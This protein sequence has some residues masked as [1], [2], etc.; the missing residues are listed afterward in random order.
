MNSSSRESAETLKLWNRARQVKRTEID[1][2]L[3]LA[4]YPKVEPLA[5][6]PEESFVAFRGVREV[7][8]DMPGHGYTFPVD[9]YDVSPPVPRPKR[10][11]TSPPVS[12]ATPA[13]T[14][15]DRAAYNVGAEPMLVDLPLLD[16]SVR[17]VG[18]MLQEEL[19]RRPEQE[20]VRKR[21]VDDGRSRGDAAS[22]KNDQPPGKR[23]RAI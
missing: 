3:P 8:A 18:L 13:Q 19:D 2:T 10:R 16:D 22:S 1:K 6:V 5:T 9:F 7:T 4:E 12:T 21:A 17:S 11:Y 20:V 14:L 23:T 15:Q